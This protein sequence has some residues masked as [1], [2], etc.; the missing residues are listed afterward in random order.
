MPGVYQAAPG[1]TMAVP[2]LIA[3]AKGNLSKGRIDGWWLDDW[4]LL[5][6]PQVKHLWFQQK[7]IREATVITTE[8]LLKG[9]QLLFA[10]GHCEAI[11]WTGNQVV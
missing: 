1:P 7:Q 3:C 5:Y 4:L 10:V 2:W 11:D 6:P 8:A 9:G